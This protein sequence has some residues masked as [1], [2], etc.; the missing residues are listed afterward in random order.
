MWDINE[1]YAIII[2]S[3]L[4]YIIIMFITKIAGLRTFAKMASVD[5]AT[6]IA[7]GSILASVILNDK[8]KVTHGAVA[9]SSIIFLNLGVAYLSKKSQSL[10][11]LIT[12]QPL[13]LM[14]DGEIL[15]DNLKDANIS[16]RDL[17]AK[18]REANAYK[19]THVKAVILETTGDISVLHGNNEQE[20][21]EI[22]LSGVQV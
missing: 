5:F 6:T 15:T 1:F 12:N 17:M 19:I 22:V 14:R 10:S 18:L 4:I 21:D 7:I 16:E 11:K 8:V 2:K 20:V 13:L 9:L 3:S